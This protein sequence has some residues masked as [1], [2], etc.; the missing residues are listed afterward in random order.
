MNFLFPYCFPVYCPSPH[1]S[2]RP[3]RT[4]ALDI[5]YTQHSAQ[6]IPPEG[7]QGEEWAKP[8]M[9]K[10]LFLCITQSV[11]LRVL[12]LLGTPLAPSLPPGLTSTPYFPGAHI[13]RR[14]HSAPWSSPWLLFL[15][16]LSPKHFILT[17]IPHL[18][19]EEQGLFWCKCN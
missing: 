13:P 4:R 5:C 2:R 6:Q 14:I 12:S 3:T 11:F 10:A 16:K 8:F 7:K 19:F 9:Q 15:Q 17:H 18:F 1:P